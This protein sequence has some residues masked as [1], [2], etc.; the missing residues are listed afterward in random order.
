MAPIEDLFVILGIVLA[1]LVCLRTFWPLADDGFLVLGAPW[2]AR[3][4]TCSVNVLL[5]TLLL[6][7]VEHLKVVQPREALVPP[8]FEHLLLTFPGGPAALVTIVPSSPWRLRVI[9][10]SLAMRTVP[11]GK[12]RRWSVL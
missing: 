11:A 5:P 10:S 8:P 3:D 7:F 2:A 6:P 1:R 9:I 4:R 12:P